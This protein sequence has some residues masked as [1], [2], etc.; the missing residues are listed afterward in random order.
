MVALQ[1]E[2]LH[3]VARGCVDAIRESEG[4][5]AEALLAET[6]APCTVTA[7]QAC[8]FLRRH[9]ELLEQ[10]LQVVAHKD[11]IDRNLLEVRND[12][13]TLAARIESGQQVSVCVLV[14]YLCYR[15]SGLIWI[16]LAAVFL[17][18]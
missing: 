6:V 8:D 5:A 16:L 1:I 3:N 10:Q 2:T 14:C 4:D 11:L 15:S 17:C 7:A 12:W 18:G 13:R 9:S